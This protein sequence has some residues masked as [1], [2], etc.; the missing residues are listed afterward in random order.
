ML[1]VLPEMAYSQR[2]SDDVIS[3]DSSMQFIKGQV[4]LEE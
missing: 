2:T 4:P 3:A 1:L